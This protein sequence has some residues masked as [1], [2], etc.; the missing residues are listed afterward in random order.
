MAKKHKETSYWPHM[1]LGFLILGITLSY[2]TVKSASS[3]PVQES[4]EY[5]MKY[6]Q[7]DL[8]IN[9]ILRHKALFDKDYTIKIEADSMMFKVENSKAFKSLRSVVLHPGKNSFTYQIM[10]HGQT[11]VADM[12]VTF[13]LTRPHTTKEDIYLT[14]IPYENGRYV[15][16]DVNI[17]KPGRYILQLRAQKGSAI[18]YSEIPGYLKVK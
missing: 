17:S 18:G 4:N 1:I 10:T 11:P 3:I 6:Q 13:L 12:N 15:V 8:N 14:H 9:D 5:M 7:A 16:R 2:W